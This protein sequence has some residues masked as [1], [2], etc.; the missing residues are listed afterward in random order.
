MTVVK[1]Q[2]EYDQRIQE[3]FLVEDNDQAFDQIKETIR[4]GRN[5]GLV[6]EARIVMLTKP[7]C[8][9]CAEEKE[10]KKDDLASGI[11]QEIDINSPEG[12]LLAALNG[13][14]ATPAVLVLDCE[15]RV[16]ESASLENV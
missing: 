1:T 5:S 2:A 12:Q 6:C 13:I 14:E 9:P 3:A 16:I 15:N 8:M 7:G 11:I 4:S 10:L